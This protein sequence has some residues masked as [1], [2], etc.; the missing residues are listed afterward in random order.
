[1]IE[2]MVVEFS[3][4]SSGFAE[5]THLLPPTGPFTATIRSGRAGEG[6]RAEMAEY[7]GEKI[8]MR[9]ICV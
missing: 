3:I 1:V 4:N 9:P 2:L 6:E 5:R 8:S 7:V